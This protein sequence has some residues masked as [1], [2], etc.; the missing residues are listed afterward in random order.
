LIPQPVRLPRLIDFDDS[1]FG[2]FV[3]DLA[4]GTVALAER[5]LKGEPI[6]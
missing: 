3:Y 5:F 4:A 6:T 1:G 2:W